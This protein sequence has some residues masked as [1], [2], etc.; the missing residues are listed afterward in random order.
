VY[1]LLLLTVKVPP[2][3]KPNKIPVKITTKRD[4]TAFAT[5]SW[6]SGERWLSYT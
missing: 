3:P 4:T 5:V 2:I 1:T 6:P